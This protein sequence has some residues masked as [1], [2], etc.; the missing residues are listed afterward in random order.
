MTLLSGTRLGAY[1]IVALIGAGGMGE[2]YRARDPRL[3]R[4]AAIKVLPDI[5]SKD[6]ERLA[7][8]EREARLLASLNHS[9]IGHIYGLEESNGTR[10]LVLEL[11]PGQTLAERI[12]A[13][14]LEVSEALQ[15]CRQIAEALDAAHE[16]GIIHR[17][18]KPANIKVTDEGKIKVLDFG[19]AK[20]L[21]TEE[22]SPG[23]SLSPTLTSRGVSEGIILGTAAYMSPEQARG[24]PLDKRTDIWSFGCVLYEMLTGRK[25][26]GGEAV[27]D[28]IA[29]IVHKDPDW[30]ALP[31]DTPPR[32]RDLLRHCLQ[33]DRNQRLRDIGDARIEIDSALAGPADKSGIAPAA[34]SAKRKFKESLP[35]ILLAGLFF[36][37]MLT[38]G[39]L[40]L[41]T[42]TEQPQTVR[43]NIALPETVL[44]SV[45]AG[46]SLAI[47]PDGRRLAIVAGERGKQSILLRSLYSFSVQVLPG[48]EGATLPFWSPDSRSIGFFADRKLKKTDLSGGPAVTLCDAPPWGGAWNGDGVILF[49]SREG[50]YRVP[51]VGGTP[52]LLAK[53]DPS[54]QETFHRWPWFLPDGAHF[55]YAVQSNTPENRGVYVGSLD[56]SETTRLIPTNSMTIYSPAGY[57]LFV[58]DGTL[59][60]QPFDATGLKVTGEA[61]PAAQ[62]VGSHPVSGLAAFSV[63][64]NGVLA[65]AAGFRPNFRLGWYDRRGAQLEQ[66]GEPAAYR[67]PALSPDG[68]TIAVQIMDSD[69]AFSDI[70]LFEKKRGSWT[71][72][73]FNPGNDLE[74]VWSP[75]GTRILFASNRRLFQKIASG[76]GKDELVYKSDR[77]LIPTDWSRD[78]RFI[79]FQS[80]TS[81][82]KSDVWALP[83]F[84]DRKAYP[85]L[86][87]EFDEKRGCLSPDGKWI[88]YT[89]NESGTS[90]IY[91]QSFPLTGGKWLISAK[92]KGGDQPAWRREGKELFY[93]AP[94]DKIMSVSVN[95]GSSS[96]DPGVPKV[97]FEANLSTLGDYRNHYVPSADGQRFLIYTP[98]QQ[99]LSPPINVVLNWTADLKR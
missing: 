50:L 31:E 3:G 15:L 86:Q 16:K 59:M 63:S 23:V 71:R 19:L 39:V 72:F 14:P 70:W 8:F 58:Q 51:A 33:K 52:V 41:R 64:G 40:Y 99:A 34:V 73:T 94:D 42:S 57:L 77:F 96:F 83:L 90:E 48:T 62:E 75:D 55:L 2:V 81:T 89:S 27:T 76:A 66:I 43:S 10:F 53:A 56:S 82:T 4:E 92:G 32:V 95:A 85:V 49:G 17:D 11:V 28:I 78:G 22:S 20:A 6:P 37:G 46:N 35:W 36:L 13:G 44:F 47:S 30:N 26:F 5:F 91:V 74:P 87:G 97:L 93:L 65:Y 79:L 9:N 21:V 80:G 29:A 25:A 61:F 68:N 38:I 69:G 45:A 54:R 60:A 84:G 1:E 67:A 12:T 24:K 7:R 18:L 98:V 88:A